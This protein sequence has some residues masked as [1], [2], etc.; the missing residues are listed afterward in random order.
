MCVGKYVDVHDCV[1]VCLRYY[2]DYTDNKEPSSSVPAKLALF[3][4]L[5][6]ITVQKPWATLHF[7]M[8]LWENGK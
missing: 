4:Y 5:K 7:F 1:C 3:I 8:F 6:Y 2:K